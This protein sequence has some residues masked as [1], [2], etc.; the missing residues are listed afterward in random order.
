MTKR[1][2]IEG[3]VH[4]LVHDLAVDLQKKRI[5]RRSFLRSATLLGLSA[6]T[7][8]ALLSRITGEHI[9]PVAQAAEGKMGGV[10]RISMSVQEMTD[11]ALFD[12][13]EKSNI[14]RQIVEYLTV[15]GAD[16]ITRPY[17]AESW[18]A[19]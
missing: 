11:P 5:D 14:A 1:I 10:L 19:S 12:W 16:N 17:L 8:Y 3:R 13:T 4:P 7:A 18:E 15:T 2:K 9:M 6:T